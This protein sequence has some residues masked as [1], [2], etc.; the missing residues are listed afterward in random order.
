VSFGPVFVVAVHP[1]LPR[2]PKFLVPHL[3]SASDLPLTFPDIDVD[4]CCCCGGVWK[5]GAGVEKTMSSAKKKPKKTTPS[6]L[7]A[8]RGGFV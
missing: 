2:T 4:E 1:H 5:T 6:R 3:E 8:R 7:H